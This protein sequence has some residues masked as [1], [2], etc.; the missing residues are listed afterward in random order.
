MLNLYV[1]TH[2]KDS[3]HGHGLKTTLYPFYSKQMPAVKTVIAHFNIKFKPLTETLYTK[4][5]D[6]PTL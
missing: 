5:Y 2:K 6:I 4:R 1:T 3:K